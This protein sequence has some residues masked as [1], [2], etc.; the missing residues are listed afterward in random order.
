MQSNKSTGLIY[1]F[2]LHIMVFISA[3]F[4]MYYGPR[5]INE[6]EILRLIR[7][8]HA[9]PKSKLS[10]LTGLS[11]QS[12]TVIM[13]KLEADNLVIRLPAVKGGVGQPKVP[14]SLNPEGAF[15]VG[16]TIGRRSYDMTLLDLTGK[17][18]N[19]VEEVIPYPTPES[20][21][22][23]V[24]RAYA[25]LVMPLSESL[26]AK[27]SGLGVAMPFDMWQWAD[28]IGAPV[29][30]LKQWEQ[31]DIKESVSTLLSLDV[32]VRNDA[33]AACNGELS[34]GNCHQWSDFLYLYVGT[35][36]GGGLVL[37]NRLFSGKTGKA[38]AVG[39]LPFNTTDTTHQLINQS[40][41]CLL[42]RQLLASGEKGEQLYGNT[43]RWAFDDG[44]Q[45]EWLENTAQG[46]TFAIQCAMS[47]L[48][49]QGIYIDGA[50]PLDIKQKLVKQTQYALGRQDLRGLSQVQ[51][52]AGSIGSN[53]PSIGS[54]NV[55]LVANFF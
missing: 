47:L 36:I 50:I 30:A 41:L 7:T 34:L 37:D 16:L 26:Q 14:F 3:N 23:F 48:D 33:A 31:F 54:A 1:C 20:L 11:A 18:R 5:S 46:L 8:H 52:D 29:D 35:F 2:N 9:L 49:L 19:K 43:S 10:H 42:E 28:E 55:P 39:T 21:M 38:G 24:R 40:S 13:N 6:R 17:V 32:F 4:A 22:A 53:A 15:G 25:T 51:V 44:L 12:A 27:I 45:Q